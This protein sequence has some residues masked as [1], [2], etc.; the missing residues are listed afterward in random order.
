MNRVAEARSLRNSYLAFK[1]EDGTYKVLMHLTKDQASI[2][3]WELGAGLFLTTSKSEGLGA[4]SP[5]CKDWKRVGVKEALSLI[6][7][8]P[9]RNEYQCDHRYES[10]AICTSLWAEHYHCAKCDEPCQ[11]LLCQ[12][13]RKE[14]DK[15]RIDITRQM[16][17][18][19]AVFG[20]PFKEDEELLRDMT[21]DDDGWSYS[22]GSRG[23]RED[24]HADG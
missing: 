13:C 19:Q 22:G 17:N 1:Q 21:C 16:A 7:T 20:I 15:V 2:D 6:R 23:D 3:E 12:D 24:F 10:G 11:G 5:D 18:Y 9:K 14:S 8:F 4:C